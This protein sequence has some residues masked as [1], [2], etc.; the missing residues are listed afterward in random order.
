MTRFP[1]D[2]L[3]STD[4]LLL[5]PLEPAD[6]E[7]LWPDIADPEISQLMAWEPHKTKEQTAAFIDNEIKRRESGNGVTWAI[8]HDGTFCGIISLI[9][10]LQ[11]HRA[12]TYNKAD[13]AYWTS[14]SQQRRGFMTEAGRRVLN[15]AFET[16]GLHKVYV[17]HFAEN[18]ASR[19]LIRRLGFRFI[20]TQRAEF[21]KAGVW[22]DHLMYELLDKEYASLLGPHG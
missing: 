12:L 4:R 3:L 6:L 10:I 13:L 18:Q 16:L 17:S 1:G 2:L 14:R 5:R 9:G 15:F 19:A 20:G 7:L 21:Q 8:L 22:H 11:T